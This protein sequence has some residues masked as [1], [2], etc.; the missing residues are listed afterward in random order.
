MKN[1][2]CFLLFIVVTLFAAPA[3][4]SPWKMQIRS[5]AD[6]SL[7]LSSFNNNSYVDYSPESLPSDVAN[8]SRM[9]VL[10]SSFVWSKD[11]VFTLLVSPTDHPCRIYVNG[12]L[13][14]RFGLLVN[15]FVAV[16]YKSTI[17]S[18]PESLANRGKNDIT[19][20][21][22]PRG[23]R[24]PPPVTIVDTY[25]ENSEREFWQTIVYYTYTCAFWIMGL[26][27][28]I[29]FLALWS[30]QK[31]EKKQYLFFALS[32][33]TLALGYSNVIFASADHNEP[34]L[35]VISRTGLVLG[36]SL[37]MTFASIKAGHGE[38][39]KWV[40]R[41][42]I[43]ASLVFFFNVMLMDTKYQI[44]KAYDWA[45]SF[46]ITPALILVLFH[47]IV[48]LSRSRTFL[49]FL[50][51]VGVLFTFGTGFHD[52]YYLKNFKIPYCW[53]LV[54]GYTILELSII[55]TLAR[56]LW[57][58]FAENREKAILLE[59]ANKKLLD[60]KSSLEQSSE[61]K[62]RFLRN[63]AHE[64]KTPLQGLVTIADLLQQKDTDKVE[65]NDIMKMMNVQMQK[66]LYNIQNV[67]DMSILEDQQPEI[68]LKK[69]EVES[70]LQSV[71]QMFS[72]NERNR[73]NSLEIISGGGLPELLYGANDHFARIA[74]NLLTNMMHE[75]QVTKVTC[76]ANWTESNQ[77][78]ELRMSNGTGFIPTRTL[79]ILTDISHACLSNASEDLPIDDLA[80]LV[81]MQ[82]LPFLNGSLEIERR[83]GE[84]ILRVPFKI[85]ASN[86]VKKGDENTILVVEDNPVN[87]MLITR[88]IEKMGYTVLT[89]EDGLEAVEK[90]KNDH[91][92][93]ILMD[94]QMPYM[95]G[96]EATRR[97][98]D[99]QSK[100]IIVALTANGNQSECMD[101]GM[102]DFLGKPANLKDIKK[103]LEHYLGNVSIEKEN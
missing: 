81:V 63:M 75:D 9:L 83:H 19:M 13:I 88:L 80:L 45:S 69:F 42:F 31:K 97:I 103:I 15:P 4:Q 59:V 11:E 41:V 21:L 54:F 2:Y 98:R 32:S 27:F 30:V 39:F 17:V 35:W 14:Y 95:D 12:Q 84:L 37:I 85:V 87:R 86:A 93:L 64:F 53:T 52:L 46:I 22:F 74:V 28:G 24:T 79:Q 60:Q 18:I 67:M 33:I 89:A 58:V 61:S 48:Q 34:F 72:N 38:K 57:V 76:Y 73:S 56:D 29:L 65:L 47:A 99:S 3:E 62:S 36:S 92:A 16:N 94:V 1:M 101:A 100:V 23:E 77:M 43:F 78:I 70:L 66:H 49:D 71:H 10:K 68:N 82:L 50:V 44:N 20:V 91:P 90:A 7:P 55:F 96:L 26:V 25:R 6:S 51:V 102:D 8:G 5:I 40:N